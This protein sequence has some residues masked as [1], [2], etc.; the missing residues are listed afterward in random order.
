M[1]DA[2]LAMPDYNNF[3]RMMTEAAQQLRAQ[4][5]TARSDTV[6]D[7]GQLQVDRPNI[8]VA[9]SNDEVM[10]G[11]SAEQ[12][13]HQPGAVHQVEFPGRQKV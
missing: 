13:L 7:D 5:E 8:A 10:C 2:I 11:C 9:V 3:V 6:V 1:A 12:R 4:A